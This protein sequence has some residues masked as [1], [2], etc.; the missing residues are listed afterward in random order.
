MVSERLP[1][2]IDPIR[3]AEHKRAFAGTIPLAEM[4]RATALL[5]SDEGDIDVEIEGGIDLEGRPYIKGRLVT[6]VVMECQRCLE[7]VQCSIDANF[8]LAPVESEAEMDLL[9]SHYEPLLWGGSPLYLQEVL[10]DEL[11]LAL[12]AIANHPDG[13]C[14]QQ[15]LGRQED[16]DGPA[17]PQPP[18]ETKE[19][20][21]ALLRTLKK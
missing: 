12:P 19:S 2:H 7:P 13:S 11:I 10:E 16:E 9:P 5:L 15:W 1:V 8:S 18:S 6:G 17:E 4:V 20:P 21:F 3:I 14:G